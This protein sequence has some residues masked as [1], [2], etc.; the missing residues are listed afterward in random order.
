MSDGL[1]QLFADLRRVLFRL[2]ALGVKDT[3][4]LFH[5]LAFPVADQGL[6]DLEL[7]GEFGKLFL[8]P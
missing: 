8:A 1:H 4:T 3:G 2:L 7:G 5:Q 6:M